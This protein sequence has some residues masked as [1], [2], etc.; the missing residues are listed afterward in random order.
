ML[1]NTFKN[2]SKKCL[3]TLAYMLVYICKINQRKKE[4]KME[5]LFELDLLELVEKDQMS[6]FWS[7]DIFEVRYDDNVYG[8]IY[9]EGKYREPNSFD[10]F[11]KKI[12]FVRFDG[13]IFEKVVNAEYNKAQ[14]AAEEMIEENLTEL[15]ENLRKEIT[16]ENC[17]DGKKI[18]VGKS[19]LKL[20]KSKSYW[21]VLKTPNWWEVQ[22]RQ[23]NFIDGVPETDKELIDYLW[24]DI[25]KLVF[26]NEG[27]ILPDNTERIKM[28]EQGLRWAKDNLE[29]GQ[30]YD[31]TEFLQKLATL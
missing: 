26:F 18:F 10:R 19:Y 15:F 6:E 20:E 25:L 8:N 30:L 16:V 31:A 4:T 14:N 12:R 17:D 13:Q 23:I 28:I 27:H 7:K 9:F 21:W 3:Q 29:G 22:E 24:F 5:E 1:K 2:G 11:Y